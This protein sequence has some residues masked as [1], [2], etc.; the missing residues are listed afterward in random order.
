MKL[1]I[2]ATIILTFMLATM[3]VGCGNTDGTKNNGALTEGDKNTLPDDDKNALP[4]NESEGEGDNIPDNTPSN[5]NSDN[6]KPDNNTDGDGSGEQ[7]P[8]GDGNGE[9]IPEDSKP[10]ENIPFGTAVGYRFNDLTLRTLD[11]T[12]VNTADLRG[13]VIIFNVWATWCPPCKAELP[14]FNAIAS[15]YADDVVIIAAHKYDE[16]SANM[17]SYVANNFKNTKIIFAYDNASNDAYDAAGGIGYV[18]QTAII[19][20]DG[21]IRYSDSGRLLYSTLISLIQDWIS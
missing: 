8:G 10:E 7:I 18:P 20:K 12:Y 3:L 15:E 5:E 6:L 17:P 9:Q 16:Y 13:K 11:G 21:I 2:I 4:D 14:D 1:K 19:D